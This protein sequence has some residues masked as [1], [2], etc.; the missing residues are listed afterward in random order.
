MYVIRKL[1]K[2]NLIFMLQKFKFTIEFSFR[3]VATLQLNFKVTI[4]FS[5]CSVAAFPFWGSV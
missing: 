3:I 4:E 1:Q 5:F 2:K